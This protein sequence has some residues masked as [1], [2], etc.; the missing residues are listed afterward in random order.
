MHRLVAPPAASA[1]SRCA[2]AQYAAA[3]EERH[4]SRKRA[5]NLFCT[6]EVVIDYSFQMSVGGCKL[7]QCRGTDNWRLPQ[8]NGLFVP[9]LCFMLFVLHIIMSQIFFPSAGERT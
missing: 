4:H 8:I 6:T 1:D 5:R 7:A 2:C 9:A 3:L